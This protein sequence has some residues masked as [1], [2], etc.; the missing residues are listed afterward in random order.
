MKCSKII[1]V[2]ILYIHSKYDILCIEGNMEFHLVF[3]LNMF[4]NIM[5]DDDII[6]PDMWL[7]ITSDKV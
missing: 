5:H 2:C 4:Y 7:E 3:R 6:H 1:Q